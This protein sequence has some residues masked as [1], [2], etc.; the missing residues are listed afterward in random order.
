MGKSLRPLQLALRLSRLLRL[1]PRSLRR[2][3]LHKFTSSKQ[4][5][6][7]QWASPLRLL[8]RTVEASSLRRLAHT[9]EALPA[10]PLARMA[11]ASRLAWS[12]EVESSVLRPLA[13][14][15]LL[16]L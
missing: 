4:L 7:F 1:A 10:R 12:V 3:L 11:E 16:A 8:A 15:A 2:L 6:L 5:A 13:L 14:L 9:V